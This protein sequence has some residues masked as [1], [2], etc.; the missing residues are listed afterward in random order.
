MAPQS[1]IVWND[2]QRLSEDDQQE[3]LARLIDRF[4]PEVDSEAEFDSE[5]LRRAEEL[6][7]DPS[8]GIPWEQVRRM[9]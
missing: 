1:E 5:L 6:R 9:R 8:A 4:E 2:L 3:L 7:A